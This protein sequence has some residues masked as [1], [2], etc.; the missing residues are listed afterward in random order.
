MKLPADSP[1]WLEP[2]IEQLDQRASEL[3]RSVTVSSDRAAGY[4]SAVADMRAE[5]QIQAELQAERR[6]KNLKAV[7]G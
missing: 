2:L 4:F 5:I 3:V 7:T 1:D 6:M